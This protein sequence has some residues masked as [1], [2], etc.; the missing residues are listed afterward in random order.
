MTK[1]P[2]KISWCSAQ[3]KKALFDEGLLPFKLFTNAC[4]RCGMS[5][6][7]FK[8]TARACSPACRTA[9]YKIN[10][11]LEKK[12]QKDLYILA[13]PHILFNADGSINK[14][15]TKSDWEPPV[16]HLKYKNGKMLL[17]WP[18]NMPKPTDRKELSQDD[19][20]K[21]FSQTLLHAG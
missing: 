21:D 7:T 19:L 2:N 11:K 5:F 4:A 8:S 17:T 9:L 14:D 20:L 16:E 15:I 3:C 6:V 1:K 10:K 18:K 12:Q 13:N